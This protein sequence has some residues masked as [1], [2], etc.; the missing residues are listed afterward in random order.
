MSDQYMYKVQRQAPESQA[1]ETFGGSNVVGMA[2][3]AAEQL[4]K[5]QGV[6]TRVV[7]VGALTLSGEYHKVWGADHA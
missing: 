5:S 7:M 6:R 3:A 1:W 4:A 2:I